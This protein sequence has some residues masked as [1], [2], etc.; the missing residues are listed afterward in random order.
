MQLQLQAQQHVIALLNKQGKLLSRLLLCCK[1]L[2]V[3]RAVAL[4]WKRAAGRVDCDMKS[5]LRHGLAFCMS[6]IYFWMFSK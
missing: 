3:S 4:S 6:S 1:T 5:L 2:E